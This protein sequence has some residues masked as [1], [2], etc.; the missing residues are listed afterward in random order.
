MARDKSRDLQDGEDPSTTGA[1]T[2]SNWDYFP[3]APPDHP[4]FTAGFII[5]R[6]H[7]KNSLVAPKKPEQAPA[8]LGDAD[9]TSETED[10]P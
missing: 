1:R 8:K 4:I 5:G 9:L 6:T 10:Q 3:K 7:T 2:G